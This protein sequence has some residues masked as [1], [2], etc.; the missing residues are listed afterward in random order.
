LG[1]C[2]GCS[3]KTVGGQGCKSKGQS[4]RRP[5]EEEEKSKLAALEALKR[6]GT[7]RKTKREEKC[8]LEPLAETAVEGAQCSL[9]R[10]GAQDWKGGRHGKF[11]STWL[12]VVTK[13]KEEESQKRISMGVEGKVPGAQ[14]DSD[15]KLRR[16]GG[17]GGTPRNR[18]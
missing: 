11:G 1:R 10:Q 8:K 7:R 3:F 13:G 12:S 18:T 16:G 9:H 5:R 4:W 17:G 2:V 15:V 6:V 14:G